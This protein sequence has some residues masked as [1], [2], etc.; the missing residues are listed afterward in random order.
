MTAT[1]PETRVEPVVERLHGA[2]SVDPY[3][4]LQDDEGAAT[5]AWTV[6]QNA[7]TAG[8]LDR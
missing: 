8:V 5:S 3:R 4:G 1:V 6:A 2:E 7:Y